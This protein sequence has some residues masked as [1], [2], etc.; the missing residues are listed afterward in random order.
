MLTFT[1]ID[2]G[3][4]TPLPEPIDEWHGRSA[5]PHGYKDARHWKWGTYYL[6]RDRVDI[7]FGKIICERAGYTREEVMSRW[8]EQCPRGRLVNYGDGE[9]VL[10]YP[11]F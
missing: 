7:V 8:L 11:L 2:L 4:F 5:D 3:G 9:V 10:R 1:V 6:W